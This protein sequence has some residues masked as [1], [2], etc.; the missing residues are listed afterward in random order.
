M[1]YL[2]IIRILKGNFNG[3]LYKSVDLPISD[4]MYD[5]LLEKNI[6]YLEEL[7]LE[8]IKRKNNYICLTL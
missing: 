1:S 8:L 7:N 2:K 6:S 5:K 3:R 4:A